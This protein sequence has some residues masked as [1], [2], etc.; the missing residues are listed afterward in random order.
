MVGSDSSRAVARG[1]KR[2]SGPLPAVRANSLQPI[3]RMPVRDRVRD[4]KLWDGGWSALAGIA[5]ASFRA[6]GSPKQ[7][8]SFYVLSIVVR[9]AG[10]TQVLAFFRVE[11][12]FPE[13]CHLPRQNQKTAIR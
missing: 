7:A 5:R 3:Y 1:E 13:N 6:A 10:S 9:R 12:C 4:D 2:K 11:G 8:P